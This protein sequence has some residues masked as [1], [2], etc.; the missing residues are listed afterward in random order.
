MTIKS[1][2]ATYILIFEANSIFSYRFTDSSRVL[3]CG[4][5]MHLS[6]HNWGGNVLK[7]I[8]SIQK[9]ANKTFTKT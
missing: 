7:Q 2:S 6:N 3:Y 5:N 8:K 9:D 1:G 4:G